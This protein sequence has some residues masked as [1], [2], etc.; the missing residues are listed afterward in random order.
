MKVRFSRATNSIE[1]VR[2]F[3]VQGLGLD[4]LSEFSGHEGFDGIMLGKPGEEYHLEFTHQS[5]VIVAGAPCRENL[6]VF[7]VPNPQEWKKIVDRMEQHGFQAKASHNPFWDRN[8]K[9]FEDFEGYG[10]VIYN[11]SWDK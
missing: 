6:I 2:E 1:R 4:I 7:Y 5:G 9:L 8:G 10:V 3:Y 11:D